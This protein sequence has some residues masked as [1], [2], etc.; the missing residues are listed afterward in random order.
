MSCC[1]SKRQKW[2]ANPE[3]GQS[4]TAIDQTATETAVLFRYRGTQSL[5]VTG[6]ITGQVYYFTKP[7]DEILI[8]LHDVPGMYAVPNVERLRG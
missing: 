1:G 5:R 6:G 8:N 3:A 2:S 4:N 7:G